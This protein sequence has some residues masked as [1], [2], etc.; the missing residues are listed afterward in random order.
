MRVTV[1]L[2]LL[3]S[4]ISNIVHTFLAIDLLCGSLPQPSPLTAADTG[5]AL[6]YSILYHTKPCCTNITEEYRYSIIDI[7]VMIDLLTIVRESP[8]RGGNVWKK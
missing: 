1:G 2:R 8:V 5:S 3:F 6:I 7:F 4:R